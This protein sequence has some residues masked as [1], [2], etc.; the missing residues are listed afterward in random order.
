MSEREQLASDQIPNMVIDFDPV[1]IF[2]N[3]VSYRITTDR[4]LS[5]SSRFVVL[6]SDNKLKCPSS[7]RS[8][9]RILEIAKSSL[10]LQKSGV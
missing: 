4:V 10:F 6:A 8:H 7:E 2:I 9:P 1:A 5:L 3:V